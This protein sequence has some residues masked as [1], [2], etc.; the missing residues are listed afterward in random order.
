MAAT[1]D[2]AAAVRAALRTLV[3]RN[4]LALSPAVRLAASDIELNKA[5]LDEAADA[6]WRAISRPG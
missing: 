1:A 4:E 2:R 5:Q 3:A 6:C